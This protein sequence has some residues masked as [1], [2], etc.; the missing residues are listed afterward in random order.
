MGK[1]KFVEVNYH[2]ADIWDDAFNIVLAH[3]VEV[4]MIIGGVR[5]EQMNSW[6]LDA[7]LPGD[8]LAF[9]Y[10]KDDDVDE[11][12]MIAF[13]HAARERIVAMGDVN[14]ET[15][16]GWSLGPDGRK[17]SGGALRGNTAVELDRLLEV[18]DWIAKA[19]RWE[20]DADG[21]QVGLPTRP[22]RTIRDR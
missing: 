6:I 12:T 21:A 18:V 20:P 13:V 2:R 19:L 4:A 8:S 3:I 10:P 1:T 15:V 17:V 16:A 22:R 9:T 14:P 5:D 7:T 11:E